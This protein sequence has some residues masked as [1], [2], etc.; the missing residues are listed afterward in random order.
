MAFAINTKTASKLSD[1]KGNPLLVG[2]H[3]YTVKT[4]VYEPNKND[5]TGKEKQVVVDFER[6]GL[7]HRVWFATESANEVTAQIALKGLTS[8]AVACDF[9]GVLKP[10]GLKKLEG[11]DVDIEAKAT[12]GKG[13]NQGKTFVNIVDI[14][15]PESE[16]EEEEEEEQEEV[17]E[18]EAEQEAEPEPKGKNKKPWEK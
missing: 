15:A 11:N 9:K 3:R 17:E 1:N 18:T 14:T 4:V 10:E 6:E 8:L 5:P 13:A 16:E 2:K 7:S 12:P